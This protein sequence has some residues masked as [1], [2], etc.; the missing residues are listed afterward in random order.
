[1]NIV[2]LTQSKFTAVDK[3]VSVRGIIL[4]VKKGDRATER[5]VDKKEE[6]SLGRVSKGSEPTIFTDIYQE[7]VNIAIWQRQLNL[8]LQQEVSSCLL[9][10]PI[11]QT[12]MTVS[13]ESVYKSLAR[14]L[15][16]DETSELV[17]NIAELVDMFCS[18]FELKRVGLRLTALN[19]A[20][21]PKFHVDRVPCRL[22]T[23]YQ[24]I[25]TE[26]LQHSSVDRAKLGA[27]S[28]GLPDNESGIYQKATDIQRLSCA[29]VA[30]LKGESWQGNEGAGL[31]HR[32]PALENGEHRLLLTLD[33]TD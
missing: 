17:E 9:L 4:G 32:S 13:S 28:N 25:A 11:F 2:D 31:V 7:N 3:V 21:C 29:D 22:I 20:M 23:T 15:G 5:K 26:W 24:G 16:I 12:A 14:E 30:L 6:E 33:F 1:M 10:N 8:S 18:L 19:K 27:G